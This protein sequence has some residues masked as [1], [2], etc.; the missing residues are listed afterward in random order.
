[1]E[2]NKLNRH[3]H[4][5]HILPFIVFIMLVIFLANKL[6]IEGVPI[7]SLLIGKMAPNFSLSSLY[8]PHEIYT[9]K[10]LLGKPN[11]INLWSANCYYCQVEHEFISEL[12]LSKVINIIGINSGNNRHQAI[13]WLKKFS[14]PYHLTLFDPTGSIGLKW[15]SYGTPESYLV[16]ASGTICYRHVGPLNSDIWKKM[17]NE[18]DLTS[19]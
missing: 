5:K 9:E 19:I 1:M 6:K 14:D 16:Q 3:C 8:T 13:A 10:L 7:Q 12:A 15:G 2:L 4:L 17:L 11:L 18:C